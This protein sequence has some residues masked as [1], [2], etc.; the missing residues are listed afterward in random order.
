MKKYSKK[1][2]LKAIEHWTK[3]LYKL[4]ES[5]NTLIHEFINVFG[6][7]IV[8]SLDNYEKIYITIDTIKTIYKISNIVLFDSK[9]TTRNIEVNNSI[10]TKNLKFASYVF[11]SAKINGIPTYIKQKYTAKNGKVFY[12]PYIEISALMLHIKMPFA[13]AVSI[14]VHEM[15]HQ[16]TIEHGTELL[17]QDNDMKTGK[18][19]DPHA[20]EFK[21]LMDEINEKYGLSIEVACDLSNMNNEFSN[22]ISSIKKMQES[23]KNDRKIIYNT[24][25]ITVEK[26]CDDE[27]IYVT[28]IY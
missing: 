26:P 9:L 3:I 17:E 28:H 22:S 4:N 19:H 11:A 18:E 2:I 27:E 14:I 5:E 1:Q 23:E 20:G 8:Y 24:K 6:K 15:L 7:D 12:P 10:D 13:Y 25:Y 16:Y 21:K